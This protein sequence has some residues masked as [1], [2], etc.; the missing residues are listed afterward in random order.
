MSEDV[1][2]ASKKVNF[3]TQPP[4]LKLAEKSDLFEHA[5]KEL[6]VNCVKCG[7]PLKMNFKEE[8][9]RCPFCSDFFKPHAQLIFLLEEEL[10]KLST[11]SPVTFFLKKKWIKTLILATLLIGFIL[12][13]DWVSISF[14]VS[15]FGVLFYEL[16][17][18]TNHKV[19]RFK[20]LTKLLGELES[21]YQKI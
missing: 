21:T 20:H 6:D 9:I 16:Y 3:S 14:L 15:I 5:S 10:Q 1:S 12:S 17:T 19:K 2:F 7:K 18:K 11:K 13:E 4:I 8:L